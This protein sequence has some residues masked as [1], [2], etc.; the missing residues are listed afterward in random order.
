[1]ALINTGG[2]LLLEDGEIV[3]PRRKGWVGGGG[4]IMQVPSY[5]DICD[6]KAGNFNFV[7]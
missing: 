4:G 6:G 3:R 7:C 2:R 1:M 5:P